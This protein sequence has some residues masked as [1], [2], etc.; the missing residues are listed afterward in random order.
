MLRTK[1][2]CTLG[3]ATSRPE[4]VLGLAERGMDLAR[5]NMAHGTR[6]EHSAAIASVRDAS[7]L[8]GRPIAIMADLAG[9][10]IRVGKL[11]EPVSL[12]EGEEVVLAYEGRVGPGEV[13]VT[14]EPLAREVPRDATLMVDDGHIELRRLDDDLGRARFRVIHGGVMQSS[15]GI[16]IPFADLSAPSLTE[17]DIS[18]LDFALS[19]GVD[20]VAL[21]FV[22]KVDDVID[23]KRRVRGGAMVVSKI[24]KVQA[25]RHLED[26]LTETDM[27]MIARGDLGVELPFERVPLAQKR[28]IQLANYYARPVITATQMLESMLLTPRP[29]RAE[30]SD[31]ANAIL[32]GT[33]AVM[34]SGETAVGNHPLKALEALVRIGTEIERSGFLI[35]GPRYLYS[36]GLMARGGASARE[37]AVAKSTVDA[38]Q[39][40][41]APAVIVLTR[42]GSSARLVSSYRPSV[43]IFAVT[44]DRHTHR[45]L[46]A[47]WGVRPVLASRH[48]AT[49]ESQTDCGKRA[50][51]RSG[52]GEVGAPIPVTAGIPFDKPGST[53]MMRL[54]RL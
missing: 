33:D 52:V 29:T 43:P 28:I 30:A 24:E 2:V 20:C 22:R 26:I 15:K 21:S 37:H 6:E 11:S 31:V 51:L 9:P 49:Y 39:R 18:D 14:Y 35:R 48:E 44:P 17:K 23:L 41:G 4:D 32:D 45:Q 16:N 42:S 19:E 40:V 5:I 54:E 12:E 27:A 53:N 36:R 10:K 3:P 7:T 47:V 13:P 50:V 38:V 34:L 46:N 25:L 1:V 8:V